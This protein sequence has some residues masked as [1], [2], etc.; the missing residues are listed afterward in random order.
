MKDF[1]IIFL[2]KISSFE[3]KKKKSKNNKFHCFVDFFLFYFSSWESSQLLIVTT[4]SR[5]A[6]EDILF[7]YLRF[8]TL[9]KISPFSK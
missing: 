1:K 4:H 6:L 5:L 7:K 2:N 8:N 3:I 9:M